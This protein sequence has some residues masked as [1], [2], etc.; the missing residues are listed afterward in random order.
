MA[1]QL[2]I[3]GQGTKQRNGV[4]WLNY[5]RSD[6]KKD[7]RCEQ[8]KIF[9]Y[10]PSMFTLVMYNSILQCQELL[11]WHILEVDSDMRFFVQGTWT[12]R[13]PNGYC[14]GL[15]PFGNIEDFDQSSNF[16]T[17]ASQL[18]AWQ[19]KPADLAPN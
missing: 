14:P 17:C 13:C 10:A 19:K 15:L 16:A 2:S 3:G 4:S 1:G 11:L 8:S 9:A 18:T 6:F 5:V 7:Y 12:D